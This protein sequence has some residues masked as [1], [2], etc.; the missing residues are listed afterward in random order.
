MY[1]KL[2]EDFTD[3]QKKLD[4]EIKEKSRYERQTKLK[5]ILK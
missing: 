4:M 3:K 1:K 2:E 5:P